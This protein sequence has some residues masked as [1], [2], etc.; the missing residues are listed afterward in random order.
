LPINN[1][2]DTQIAHRLA[3]ESLMGSSHSTKHANISLHDLIKEYFN[4][5]SEIKLNFQNLM[6]EDAYL[7]KK[8]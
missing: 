3:Y 8:V 7:W 5:Q 4:V 6:K 1:I 2:F